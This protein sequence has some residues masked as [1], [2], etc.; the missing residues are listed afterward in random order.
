[1]TVECLSAEQIKFYQEN[2]YLLVENRVSP[3]ELAQCRAEI[4]RL[5]APAASMTEADDRI[6]LEDSHTPENPRVRRIKLPHKQSPFFEQLMRSDAILAPVRDLIGPNL[7][8]HT[9]KL[10][11]KA[12]G[13]GASVEW[14]QDWA[15]YPHTNDDLLAVGVMM[16]DMTLENGPLL[17]F[18]G[19]HKRAAYDHHANGV[20]SGAMDLAAAG[21]DIADAVP[22]TGPAGSITI[23]HVRTVHGSDFNRSPNDRR[24]LFYEITAAD[25][26]PVVGGMSKMASLQEYDSRILCGRSTL[27]PRLADVPVRIPQPQPESGGSIYEIQNQANARSFGATA[28]T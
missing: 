19:S 11:I 16:D 10:N 6:D 18:A 12:A 2:G 24:V 1:M 26:F 3:D 13:H 9:S 7:R 21:Y 20:F 28:E 25:A 4:E 22:L 17:V 14:H 8:L 27:N 5:S 23:H 15:F